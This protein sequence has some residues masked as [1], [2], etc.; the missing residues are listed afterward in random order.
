MAAIATATPVIRVGFN[1]SDLGTEVTEEQVDDYA[2]SLE[3]ALEEAFPAASARVSPHLWYG[4]ETEWLD[5][6][7][8]QVKEVID[9]HWERWLAQA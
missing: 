4:V 7:T 1:E 8:E 9:A 2:Y 3:E 6:T 5:A